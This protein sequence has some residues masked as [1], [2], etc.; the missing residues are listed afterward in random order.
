MKE[1]IWKPLSKMISARR[2]A[3]KFILEDSLV[4]IMTGQFVV[5][6]T[7]VDEI[8]ERHK[9]YQVVEVISHNTFGIVL[10]I[11]YIGGE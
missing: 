7:I 10:S 8:K 11:R 1:E 5:D 4:R 9:E 6:W 3:W 2:P